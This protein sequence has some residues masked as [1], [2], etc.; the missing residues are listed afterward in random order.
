[1][2]PTSAPAPQSSHAREPW[3][4]TKAEVMVELQSY[5]PKTAADVIEDPAFIARRSA[6]W[7]Q[8][9]RLTVTYRP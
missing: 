4:M 8:L 5:N 9:D 7:K 1:V 6:L 3:Q 2:S